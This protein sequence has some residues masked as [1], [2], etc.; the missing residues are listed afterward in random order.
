[1]PIPS[2]LLAAAIVTAGEPRLHVAL[3]FP[4]ESTLPPAIAAAAVQEAAAI[5]SRYRIVVDRRLPCASAP[6]EAIVLTVR[7]GRSRSSGP[8]DRPTAFA[9]INFDD[10]GTPYTLITVYV[11]LLRR[12]M[13]LARLAEISEDRWPAEVRDEV[14][15]RALG[16]VL[17]HEIG[18]YLFGVRGHSRSGLMRAVQPFSELFALSGVGFLLTRTDEERLARS[19]GR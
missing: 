4:S 9:A 8:I 17:A 5:W 6:D 11:D 3:A 16:R 10:D 19:I 12:S 2:L 13:V 18:H 15:G 14:I 1:M 7:T